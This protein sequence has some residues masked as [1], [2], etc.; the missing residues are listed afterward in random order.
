MLVHFLNNALSV[1][2]E[3]ASFYLP[4]AAMVTFQ[5]YVIYWLVLIGVIFAILLFVFNRSQLHLAKQSTTLRLGGK[6]TSLFCSP[7]FLISLCVFIG[8]TGLELIA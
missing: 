7:V 4:K 5:V 2:M 3:Y 8:L 6:V 1:V